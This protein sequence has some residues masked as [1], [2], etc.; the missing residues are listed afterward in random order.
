MKYQLLNTHFH[1]LTSNFLETAFIMEAE[2]SPEEYLLVP[3]GIIGLCVII[4]GEGFHIHENNLI[5]L[6]K[7][8]VRG[9][10][11]EKCKNKISS[12][13]KM[14][15][16]RFKPEFLQLILKNKISD[17]KEQ[18]TSLADLFSKQEEDWLLEKLLHV[19]SESEIMEVMNSFLKKNLLNENIEPRINHCLQK[20]R[21]SKINNVESLSKEVGIS[22]TSLRALFHK[23]V[24]VTPKEL[25]K[26]NRLMSAFN[27]GKQSEENLTQLA[28]T[29]G[30]YD[31]SHFIHEFKEA[32]GI[33]PLKYFSNENLIYDFY[34]FHR[35]RVN[36]FAV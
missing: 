12:N 7:I 29:L 32:I 31:Q 15:G 8:F 26:I 17:F 11:Y 36:S 1:P 13:Y 30:Y 20:I 24:G 23:H 16:F 14:I 34:N 6:P 2:E 28:Y 25:I 27:S 5:K 4:Q 9:L 21:S 35:L 10:H 19:K 3:N 22:S 33:S 18:A